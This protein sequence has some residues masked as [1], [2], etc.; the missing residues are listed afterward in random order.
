MTIEIDFASEALNYRRKFGG[1]RNQA[2]A[3][4]VGIKS[5]YRPRILDSTAGLGRD[6]FILSSLGC[7]ITMCER[8]CEVAKALS[9][10]LAKGAEDAS[11]AEI[12]AHMEL[13][14]ADAIDFLRKKPLEG[15]DVIYIDPMFP[16]RR[17]KALV[18]K[19]MRD[20]REVVGEDADFGDLLDIAL[21]QD[22]KR[23]VVKRP[24]LA[25]EINGLQPDICFAGKAGRF[26]VYLP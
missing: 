11:I 10:A 22:V 14:N 8:N 19:E 3:K 12:M 16:E 2:I 7:H 18:K 26:D 1:G 24:R 6:A 23:I 15:F 21:R 9:L 5:S 13:I 17:K 20:L 4:A 25:S